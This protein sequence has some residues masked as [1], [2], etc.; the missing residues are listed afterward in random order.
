MKTINAKRISGWTL[1]GVNVNNYPVPHG[2]CFTVETEG[3][4]YKI[5]N[6]SLENMEELNRL[7]VEFPVKIHLLNDSRA[8]I[9]DERIP[10][11]WY[12]DRWC[13]VCCPESLLPYPQ[14]L[15][16]DREIM[17]GVRTE[18]NGGTAIDF[19]KR[20]TLHPKGFD[21]GKQKSI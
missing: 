13:E 3:K 10:T 2:N 18:H 17:Q 9:H 19:T 16:H 14:R 11:S 1:I 20:P 12:D 5:V 15:T 4:D 21:D 7:G 8:I 6:F